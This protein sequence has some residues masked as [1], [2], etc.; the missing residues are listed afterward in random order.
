[1]KLPILARQVAVTTNRA[2]AVGLRCTVD[3]RMRHS[4]GC[5]R[6][7][8]SQVQAPSNFTLA[9][10]TKVKPLININQLVDVLLEQREKVEAAMATTRQAAYRILGTA[11]NSISL[12]LIRLATHLE[13]KRCLPKSFI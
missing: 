8:K 1:M 6:R 2:A 3:L 13:P 11:P 12:L 4:K 10:E 9:S 5:P 7:I